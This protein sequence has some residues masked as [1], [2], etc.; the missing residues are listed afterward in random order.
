MILSHQKSNKSDI[1]DRSADESHINLRG[2]RD[3]IRLRNP[4]E[5]K[6]AFR[7]MLTSVTSA[8]LSDVAVLPGLIPNDARIFVIICISFQR[9]AVLTCLPEFVV[10]G[11]TGLLFES[12]I[13]NLD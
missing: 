8:D 1:D 5:D 4:T 2:E 7:R 6:R 10:H 12:F 11:W 3:V 9:S 13:Y